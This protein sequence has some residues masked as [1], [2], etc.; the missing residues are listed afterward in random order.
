MAFPLK[1]SLGFLPLLLVAP[2][3][4][5]DFYDEAVLREVRLDFQ[6]S[7]WWSLLEGNYGT[8]IDIPADM[9]VDGVTYSD[10][11]VR[12]KGNTSFTRPNTEKKSFNITTNSFVAGQDVMGY[13]TLNFNNAYMDPSFMREVLFSKVCRSFTTAARGS[14]IHLI[15]NGENWGVYP[16]V[17]QLNGDFLDENYPTDTGDRFKVPSAMQNPGNSSLNWLGA[18]SASYQPWYEL[19]SEDPTAY[20]RLIDLCDILNNTNPG[21]GY[22]P[23]VDA[24]FAVDRAL[25]TLALENAF[26]DSDG[27]VHK[28]SDYALY[29]DDVHDRWNMLQRDA[30]EAFGSFRRNGWGTNGGV[31]LHPDYDHGNANLPVMN[32]LLA[33]PEAH[34]RYIAHFRTIV[35]EWMDWGRVGPVVAAWDAL[36]N[37]EV[38]A[39]TKKIYSYSDYV[40]NLDQ[41]V[42]QGNT[43]FKGLR[44]F[45]DERRAYLL[46]LAEFNQP[47]PELV[48]LRHWPP[49][50]AAGEPIWVTV[51]ASAPAG[52]S[53]AHVRLHARTRGAFEV[54]PMFDDGQHRDGLAGDGVWGARH[55]GV[56]AGARV[57]YYVSSAC[58]VPSGGAWRFLPRTAEFHSPSWLTQSGANGNPCINEFLAKNSTTNSDPAGEFDDWVEILNR[59]TGAI[60]LGGLYLS[61]NAANLTKWEIPAGSTVESGE[62]LLIWADE[63]GSQGP[64]HANFKLSGSGESIYL[65]APDGVTVLDA[66]QYGEQVDDI[67][68]GRMLDGQSAWVTFSSP[69]PTSRNENACGYR[70]YDQL[71]A[72]AHGLRLDG[73]GDPALGSTVNIQ[74][75]GAA[76]GD[77]LFLYA[78]SSFDYLDAILPGKVVLI[79]PGSLIFQRT[80]TANGAGEA[81]LS[82]PVNNP[83]LVGRSFFAQVHLPQSVLEDEVSNGLEIIICP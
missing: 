55:H 48:G 42:N 83:S 23:A 20:D 18:N 33:D 82:V 31:N 50:P 5:Q 14:F 9:T 67:S 63:D 62:V 78:S 29:R 47:E 22:L 12:F 72:A 34:A 3:S 13:S 27:Y 66:V 32:V 74:I 56:A 73:F 58:D 7:N 53:L 1:V 36:I 37:A 49:M 59:S 21:S 60:D 44:Q 8:G 54:F 68:T 46:G 28:G 38:Q 10:V 19:K 75:S 41:D 81:L 65:T 11:G 52:A 39:D 24:T 79:A 71:N 77:G 6:Q 25:W 16:N 43:V 26:M 61:D 40:T 2:L 80:L 69:T 70:A 17:Q 76:A 45:V 57:E 30:N 35:E 4:A 51:E 64:L 15:I